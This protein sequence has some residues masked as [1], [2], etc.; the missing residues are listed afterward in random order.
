MTPSCCSYTATNV[1][2]FTQV[3]LSESPYK[4][5]ETTP[6]TTRDTDR[7]YEGPPEIDDARVTFSKDGFPQFVSDTT[8]A[9]TTTTPATQPI[10]KPSAQKTIIAK[11]NQSIIGP[12]RKESSL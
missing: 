1:T 4:M 3:P 5:A 11:K 10:P 9:S 8:R 7:D 2:I 6:A 12:F